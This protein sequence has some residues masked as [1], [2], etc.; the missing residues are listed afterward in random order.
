MA[1]KKELIK[2]LISLPLKLLDGSV[3]LI[4]T[5]LR[6]VWKHTF[7]IF[8]GDRCRYYPSCSD[9]AVEALKKHGAIKGLYLAI[10]RLLHCHPWSKGGFD[11]VP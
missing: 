6:F 5:M 11:Y 7:S 4:A 8:L 9:Y 3:I 1:N 10:R 2:K